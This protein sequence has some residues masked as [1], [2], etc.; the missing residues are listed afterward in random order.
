[1]LDG[2]TAVG[3]EDILSTLVAC[4][5]I[6]VRMQKLIVPATMA[7]HAGKYSCNSSDAFSLRPTCTVCTCTRAHSMC[8]VYAHIHVCMK[9]SRVRA[10][11]Q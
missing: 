3:E 9:L 1:M 8:R 11:N 6:F 2:A 5:V 4:T 7:T 10:G